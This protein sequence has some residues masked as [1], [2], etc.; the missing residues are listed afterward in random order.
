MEKSISRCAQ[1]I[2]KKGKGRRALSRS[3]TRRSKFIKG[4]WEMVPFGPHTFVPS[5]S[6][7][8]CYSPTH[9]QPA[10][11]HIHIRTVEY[12]SKFSGVKQWC[13]SSGSYPSG[14]AARGAARRTRGD[15]LLASL[16]R[17]KPVDQ[18]WQSPRATVAGR[19][20]DQ[21]FAYK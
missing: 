21:Y 6:W 18:R 2:E 19:A 11:L 7:L 13:A 9:L 3:T 15:T 20:N 5:Q 1:K 10:S 17:D 4:R 12:S 8:L 14:F 16:V